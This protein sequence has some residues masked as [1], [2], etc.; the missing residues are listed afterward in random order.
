MSGE[1]QAWQHGEGDIGLKALVEKVLPICSGQTAQEGRLRREVVQ[2]V[3]EGSSGWTRDGQ[4]LSSNLI[5]LPP[6]PVTRTQPA[7]HG[8]R[9]W[10]EETASEG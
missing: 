4:P 3:R 5:K 6:L 9:Y 1:G 2:L 8:G 10:K 7:F